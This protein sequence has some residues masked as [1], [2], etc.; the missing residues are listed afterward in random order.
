MLRRS[1]SSSVVRLVALALLSF[2]VGALADRN[3]LLPGSRPRAPARLG[4]TFDSFWEA[5]NLVEEH[6]VDRKAVDPVR[7]THGS[8]SGMLDS[9][10]DTGHTTY[11]TPEE[12]KDLENGLKG[13][14][15]GIGARVTIQK[16]QPTILQV[17]PGSPALAAALKSGDVLLEVDGK[18]VSDLPLERVVQLVRRAAGTAVHL[19]IS[20]PGTAKTL[21]FEIERARVTVPALTWALLPGTAVAHVAL[22]E[23]G[24]GADE[25]LRE[26][27]SQARRAGAK[28]LLID[29][30]GNPGG[31]KDQAV[32]V[33]SEFLK[34]G[35]VF[36]EQDARGRRTAVPVRSGGQATDLPVCVLTD[37]GTASSAE[38]FAGALQ[39][40]GRARLVGTRTFGTGTVLE[41]F[42]LRDGSAVLLAVKEWFTPKGRQIW[43]K[44]ISPD[45]EVTLPEGASVLFPEAE[46][47][48]DEAALAKSQDRQL[49]RALELLRKQIKA[50]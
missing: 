11:L 8:I 33:T 27:L 30:R 10:G 20:R 47:A 17:L 36:L 6:Y 29:V 2:G 9:L 34:D 48:L 26:A 23:F 19:R 45:V 13:Q 35:D 37:G 43:H 7:M 1:P 46:A 44:G 14:L 21:D 28:G 50:E 39:D 31:L 38:I 49:L 3:G 12:F 22:R 15:E 41:P 18:H 42:E 40:H 32:A 16:H 24:E 25:Q 4:H 5:W